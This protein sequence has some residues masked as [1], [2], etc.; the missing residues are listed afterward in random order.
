MTLMK[1]RRRYMIIKHKSIRY[2]IS[3]D[4]VVVVI[5]IIIIMF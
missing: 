2:L 5:I 1:K 4:V 3:Y